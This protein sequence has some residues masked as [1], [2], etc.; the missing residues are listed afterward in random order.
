MISGVVM[1]L[2]GIALLFRRYEQDPTVGEA[3]GNVFDGDFTDKRNILKFTGIALCVVG[4]VSLAGAAF[5]R[6]GARHA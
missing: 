4:G 6:V 3:I 1:P 5:T 2:A